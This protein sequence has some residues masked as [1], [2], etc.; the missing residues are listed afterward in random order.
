M[1]RKLL[2]V[3]FS[4]WLFSSYAQETY[5]VNGVKDER[6]GLHGFINATL[7]VDYQTTL[8]NAVLVIQKGKVIATG[9]DVKIPKGAIVHDLKG[10]HIYPSF[11]ELSSKIGMP[12]AENGRSSGPQL[13][14]KKEGAYNSNDAIKAYF[15]AHEVF[16]TNDSE[17]DK[18]RK[19]GFGVVLSHNQDGLVRYWN[20]GLITQ[21]I[22][23]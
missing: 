23:K 4:F 10:K 3:C 17:A 12:K 18:M 15:E 11:I 20:S 8:E 7:H 21:W 2:L 19:A 22:R 1:I 14:P 16:E 5:T 13:G 6:L 9:K